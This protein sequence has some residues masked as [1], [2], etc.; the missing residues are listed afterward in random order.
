MKNLQKYAIPHGL[1]CYLAMSLDRTRFG[2]SKSRMYPDSAKV[3]V[4]L[5]TRRRRA[6]HVRSCHHSVTAYIPL[7]TFG[8]ILFLTFVNFFFLLFYRLVYI[9]YIHFHFGIGTNERKKNTEIKATIWY[10]P[11]PK[12]NH[13]TQ[14]PRRPWQWK[15]PPSTTT[16]CVD[17]VQC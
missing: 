11:W 6:G 17:V 8:T 14:K 16:I 4:P 3:L 10:R 2:T 9:M 7:R 12:Q 5:N 15:R 1:R 13:T